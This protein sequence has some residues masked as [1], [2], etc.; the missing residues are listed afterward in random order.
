V[1]KRGLLGNA[2]SA[3]CCRFLIAYH[4][5]WI[6]KYRRK[7]LSGEVAVATRD[8]IR[9]TCER[10][11]FRL[12]AV[13]TDVDH[14]H[15]F[16]SAPPSVPPSKVAML[17]KGAS[18]RHLRQRF[19]HLKDVRRDALWAPSYYRDGWERQRGNDQAVHR[20]MP[21]AIGERRRPETGV[22]AW[23]GAACRATPPGHAARVS[24]GPLSSR[25]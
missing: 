25:A 17:L 8:A 2:A 12:L 5:V 11:G 1:G 10:H 6:P 18:S 14:V 24:P 15:C 3:R 16:V 23:A 21:G 4:I 20:G 7:V 19:P 13:E 22:N 9:D